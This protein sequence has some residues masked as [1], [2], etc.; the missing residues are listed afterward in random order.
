MIPQG[1]NIP[2]WQRPLDPGPFLLGNIIPFTQQ[3][4]CHLEYFSRFGSL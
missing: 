3:S 1:T 4:W 2:V